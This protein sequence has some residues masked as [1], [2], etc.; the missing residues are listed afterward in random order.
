M[1]DTKIFDHHE[2]RRTLRSVSSGLD[3]LLSAAPTTS[4]SAMA[5]IRAIER[6]EYTLAAHFRYEEAERGFFAEVMS[7][8]PERV[9]DLDK[10]RSEHPALSS[11]LQ[12]L[13]EIARRPDLSVS[14]WCSLAADFEAFVRALQ[15]HEHAEDALVADAMVTDEGGSG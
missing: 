6:L 9:S 10:L 13:A 12:R 11:Q 3:H 14:D 8:A 5:A 1:E 7:A 4:I 15:S 2:L